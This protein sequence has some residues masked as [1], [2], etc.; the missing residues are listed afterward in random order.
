[1]TP[2]YARRTRVLAFAVLT[3][4]LL[5]AGAVAVPIAAS[6]SNGEGDGD[7]HDAPAA[8]T[9]PLPPGVAPEGVVDGR[10]ATFFAG[11]LAGG[12]IVRGDVEDRTVEPF[13]TAPAIPVAV[14]LAYDHR[15]DLLVVAGGPSGKA[16]VYDGLTGATV[17][18]STLTTSTPTFINDAVMGRDGAYLTDSF[19]PQLFRLPIDRHGNVGAAVT[20]PLSGPA[21]AF[22]PG[23]NLNGIEYDARTNKLIVVNSTTGALFAVDPA[24]GASTTIDLGAATVTAGDGLLLLGRRLYVV[25]NQLNQIDVVKLD[26]K[27]TSGRVVETITDPLLEVPT[28]IA[29][30]DGSLV[31]VNAQFGLPAGNPFEAVVLPGD[32]SHDD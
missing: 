6:A 19:N 11:S 1:M 15:N 3:T 9:I 32:D 7:G 31:L 2:N 21:A 14:G 30:V 18:V 29:D 17:A 23:F 25:R 20:I 22:V 10:D 4:A 27:L 24:T 12:Q 16:A 5:T 13:V 26:R 8:F 28:T